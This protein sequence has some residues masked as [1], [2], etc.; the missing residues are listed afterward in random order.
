MKITKVLN[1]LSTVTVAT[2]GTRVQLSAASIEAKY[3]MIQARAANTGLIYIGDN[4]VAANKGFS[5][6]AGQ[7]FVFDPNDTDRLDDGFGF[8]NLNSIYIDATVAAEGVNVIYISSSKNYT[9]P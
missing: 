6:A 7:S 5:L 8:V 3:F 4:T 2:P 1:S 9:Q